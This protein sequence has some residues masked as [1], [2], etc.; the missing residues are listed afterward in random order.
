MHNVFNGG[1]GTTK[2]RTQD[3]DKMRGEDRFRKK[4][5]VVIPSMLPLSHM[6]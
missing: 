5:E 3:E 1:D 2:A 6:K 4:D